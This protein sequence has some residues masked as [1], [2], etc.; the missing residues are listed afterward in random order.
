M[1]DNY[2]RNID[3]LRI[4]VTDLCNLRCV[5]CMPEGGVEKLRHGDILSVE[6]IAEISAAAASLGIKKIRLTGGEPLVRKGIMDIVRRTSRTPGVN[7]VALTTNGT[8]LAENAAALKEAGLTRVNISVDTFDPGKY[9]EITRGGKIGDVLAGI[10][11]AVDAGLEPIK[12]NAVLMGG[13]NDDFIRPL[14]AMTDDA[15][16]RVRFI[17]IMPIGECADWNKERFVS[18]AKV[19]EAEPSLEYAGTD[20]VSKLYRKPGSKG[21]IGLISPISN[22]FCPTCNKLRVTADGKL[23]PCLHSAEEIQIRG[24]HGEELAETIRMAILS[25]PFKHALA[26]ERRSRSRRGMSAIG[27]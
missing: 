17:E 10:R 25:K 21:S 6:E 14:I 5:Y 11:A 19:L 23:K 12:L 20:G 26:G 18:I 13:V 1:I 9:K 22:H 7:E 4:S 3:Y 2:G 15:D 24:L 27:G 8:L 16:F